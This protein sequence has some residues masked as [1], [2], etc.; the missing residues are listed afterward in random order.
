MAQMAA[1]TG[2]LQGKGLIW[3]RDHSCHKCG[4]TQ[5]GV[6]ARILGRTAAAMS[7]SGIQE[8]GHVK[9]AG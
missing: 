1:S 2:G 8:S 9:M 4:D 6:Q 7:H 3:E 5:L